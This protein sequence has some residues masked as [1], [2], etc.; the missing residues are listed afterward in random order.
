[1]FPMLAFGLS[2]IGLAT[3][4]IF[5]PGQGADYLGLQKISDTAHRLAVVLLPSCSLALLL[6]WVMKR[7]GWRWPARGLALLALPLFGGVLAYI[8]EFDSTIEEK[9]MAGQFVGQKKP[10]ARDGTVSGPFREEPGGGLTSSPLPGGDR[11]IL[12]RRTLARRSPDGSYR[13]N[14]PRPGRHPG[15]LTVAGETVL[16]T[17]PGPDY[18]DDVLVAAVD[19][20]SGSLRWMF[21]CLGNQA[22]TAVEREYL[23]LV[24]SRPSV[25]T[26]KLIHWIEPDMLWSTRIEGPVSLRPRLEFPFVWV[27]SEGRVLKLSGTSG[28]LEEVSHACAAPGKTDVVCEQGRVVAWMAGE[29]GAKSR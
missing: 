29:G 16:Y 12:D 3:G 15:Q 8:V 19:L 21:H 7:L 4:Y 14:R 17:G 9:G 22:W 2:V 23:V 28:D 1:M 27:A 5:A 20:Q 26:V 6:A 25:A 18:E 13:W 11:L 10:C 24:S